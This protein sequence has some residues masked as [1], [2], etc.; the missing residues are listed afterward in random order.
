[1]KTLKKNEVCVLVPAYNESATI[2]QVL[3]KISKTGA[4]VL[5]VDDG[6]TDSTASVCKLEKN[7][8]LI[9]H[10]HNKGYVE[11]L[12]TGFNFLSKQNYKYI[13]TLDADNQLSADDV[14]RFVDLANHDEY[15]LVVGNRNYMNRTSE[16]IFS[17]FSNIFL[18]LKDPFCGLKLY[19]LDSIKKFLP[20]DSYNLIGSELLIRSK[21]NNLKISHLSIISQIRNGES[22][23]G[24]NISGEL[25]ILKACFFILLNHFLKNKF[26]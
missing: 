25:K 1:M 13:V 21:Y 20:F 18:N 9:K 14:V 22:K 2:L 6:S 8:M 10:N 12:N 11:A 26:R 15:D 16:Y 5:V 17:L 4:T 23:F 7:V 24:N 3:N 19:R